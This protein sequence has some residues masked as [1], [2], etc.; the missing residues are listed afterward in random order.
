MGMGLRAVC[1]YAAG[2]GP[3]TGGGHLSVLQRPRGPPW[4]L[5]VSVLPPLCG[6]LA[7][8][9]PSV[10]WLLDIA[11]HSLSWCQHEYVRL[12]RKD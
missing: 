11:G 8:K 5:H 2:A 4:P 1:P 7:T 10:D 9:P 12:L 3:C 6:A